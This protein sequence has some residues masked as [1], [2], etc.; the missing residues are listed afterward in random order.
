[1]A[2]FIYGAGFSQTSFG[3]KLGYTNS[4]ITNLE[5]SKEQEVSVSYNRAGGMHFGLIAQFGLGEKT[6]ISAEL[7]FQQKGIK[8]E[9]SFDFLGIKT[10][11]AGKN[12]FNYIEIPVLFRYTGGE[13][14]KFYGNVGPYLGY[15]IGGKFKSETTTAGETETA[16]GKIKFGKE[17]ENY[18][19]DDAYIDDSYNR[20]EIGAYIGAGIMKEVGG[21]SVIFDVRYGLDFTDTNNTSEIYPDGKPDDYKPNKYNNISISLGY[22]MNF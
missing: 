10:E 3:F 21:G 6:A 14:L 20:L 4:S 22:M 13:N 19:G 5:E 7:N 18:T 1:M 8:V 15:A 9:S 17:P 16:K 12:L 11:T 2:L